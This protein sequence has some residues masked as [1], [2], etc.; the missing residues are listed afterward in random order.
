MELIQV[1]YYEGGILALPTNISQGLIGHSERQ[2][3][4]HKDKTSQR[5]NRG[6][7]VLVKYNI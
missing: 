4:K 7:S 6:C 1:L 5:K 2:K 3:H